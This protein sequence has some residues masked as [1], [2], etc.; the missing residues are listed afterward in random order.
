MFSDV[1]DWLLEFVSDFFMTMMVS[2]VIVLAI[3]AV[4]WPAVTGLMGGEIAMEQFFVVILLLTIAMTCFQVWIP[5]IFFGDTGESFFTAGEYQHK[6][7][8]VTTRSGKTVSGFVIGR[9]PL[10]NRFW[11]Q[12]EEPVEHRKKYV[13][14]AVLPLERLEFV[15]WEQQASLAA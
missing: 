15:Q 9:V 3:G 5:P 8:R 4:M 1:V 14:R 13:L 7:V 2:A 11:V 12:L 6:R 10:T